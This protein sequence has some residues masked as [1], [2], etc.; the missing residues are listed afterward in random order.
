VASA[1]VVSGESRVV[2]SGENGEEVSGMCGVDKLRS[3]SS[4]V[5]HMDGHLTLDC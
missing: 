2:V 3:V 1:G 4:S 5:R